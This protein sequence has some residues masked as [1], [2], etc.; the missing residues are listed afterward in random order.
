[1]RRTQSRSDRAST[2]QAVA[3]FF[4]DLECT[5]PQMADLKVEQKLKDAFAGI[6]EEAAGL[7]T[8]LFGIEVP[9]LRPAPA[10]TESA[11]DMASA[12][13]SLRWK[14]GSP[15]KPH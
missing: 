5:A 3:D 10:S 11:P 13:R 6:S 8:R 15:G 9:E 7:L 1:M 12:L 2:P 4:S 14:N